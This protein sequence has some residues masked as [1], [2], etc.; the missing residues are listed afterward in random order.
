[1][2]ILRSIRRDAPVVAWSYFGGKKRRIQVSRF[3]A[4][5]WVELHRAP[6][7]GSSISHRAFLEIDG[8]DNPVLGYTDVNDVTAE[9]FGKVARWNGNR[10]V[11]YGETFSKRIA[12]LELSQKRDG[13]DVMYVALAPWSTTA[14]PSTLRSTSGSGTARNGPIAHSS[15]S[16]NGSNTCDRDGST[17][18]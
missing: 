18:S 14:R 13:T 2:T 16:A 11:Q 10:W 12:D 15:S 3:E 4:G 9:K 17:S 7:A 8:N 5:E 6:R 1:M